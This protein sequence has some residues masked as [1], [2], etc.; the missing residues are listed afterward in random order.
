MR[1]NISLDEPV[2]TLSGV[3]AVLLFASVVSA[4]TLQVTRTDDDPTAQ[5][6]VFPVGGN[7][8]LRGAIIRANSTVEADTI[9]LPAGTYT[10]T[11]PPSG[12][13]TA[14]TGDLDIINP[15]EIIG[16]GA[17]FT[18]IDGNQ[19]DSVFHIQEPVSVTIDGVKIKNGRQ[20]MYPYRGGGVLITAAATVTIRRCTLISNS[21]P[22][23][24]SSVSYGGGVAWDASSGTL[25]IE[26]CTLSANS[27]DQGGG[28][29]FN[30]GTLAIR[31]STLSGNSAGNCDSFGSTPCG[32]AIASKGFA[33]ISN[34]TIS[35]NS[36]SD[37]DHHAVANLGGSM[38]LA[39]VTLAGNLPSTISSYQSGVTTIRNSIIQG[40]CSTDEAGVLVSDGGNLES[41][42]NTCGLGPFE[43]KNVADPML[44]SLLPHGGPTMTHLPL[45]GSLTIDQ[46][47][48]SAGCLSQDQRGVD[49][50]QD[51]DGDLTATCDIGAVEVQSASEPLIFVDGFESGGVDAWTSV[52]G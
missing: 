18:V 10:L 51:G 48:A 3:L 8:S 41:P 37:S 30:D 12:D 13:D 29:Y 28:V 19:F 24:F 45:S 32:M 47:I 52:V 16:V 36:S 17:F 21:A 27:A 39:S 31:K 43:H 1:S 35:G 33:L 26:D 11:I 7:C 15:L 38:T 2:R 23:P 34:T 4:A 50:P 22:H 25:T 42:G 49:R 20:E 44:S 5:S 9:E 40:S 6:C 46:P 14:A